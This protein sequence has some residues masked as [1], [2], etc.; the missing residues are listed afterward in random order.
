MTRERQ[1]FTIERGSAPGAWVL[2]GVMR[3]ESP[4]AYASALA[5]LVAEGARRAPLDLDL[6]GVLFLNS[7]GIRALADVLVAA[8]EKG[9]PITLRGRSAVPWQK[10]LANSFT[11]LLPDLVV[12]LDR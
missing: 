7:S 5:P 10:K 1:E 12:W 11:G 2:S 9:R 4:Q 6:S 3:L 8:R